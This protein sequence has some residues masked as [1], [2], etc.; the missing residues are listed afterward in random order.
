MSLFRNDLTLEN[1]MMVLG[2]VMVLVSSSII[3]KTVAIGLDII[4][5]SD[6]LSVLGLMVNSKPSMM[7]FS[8]ANSNGSLRRPKPIT[9][10][11]GLNFL[12][13]AANDPPIKPQPIML[14]FFIILQYQV[15]MMP[16]FQGNNGGSLEWIYRNSHA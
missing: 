2:L 16:L 1:S 3:G 10:V 6:E 13:S 15:V 8:F 9:S 7:L 4:I 14:I 5:A 12:T 11:D